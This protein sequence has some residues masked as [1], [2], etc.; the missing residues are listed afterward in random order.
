MWRTATPVLSVMN[1][2]R[3]WSLKYFL[4][5]FL[6]VVFLQCWFRH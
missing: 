6:I 2:A 1:V 3:Q 5:V 4:G